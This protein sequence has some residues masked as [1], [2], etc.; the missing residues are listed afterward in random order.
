M[1]R[2]NAVVLT[3]AQATAGGVRQAFR[4]LAPRVRPIDTLVFF[5]DGHGGSDVLD[6]VGPDL[7]R[8]ELGQMMNRVQGHQ[9]LVL[10]SCEAGGF[11]P[12]VQGQP[13]RA[14]LFSSRASES[15]STARRSAPA[16]GWRTRSARRWR[17]GCGGGPTAP[18]TSRT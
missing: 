14:G 5:F 2:R 9:L 10:D 7:A 16:A 1:Q 11:A 12:L 8:R 18:S 6:L 17:A 15:S 4:A 3:D 13:S